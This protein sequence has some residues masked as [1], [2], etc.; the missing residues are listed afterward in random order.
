M[1]KETMQGLA[2]DL[3]AHLEEMLEGI[4]AREGKAY[5]NSLMEVFSMLNVLT[6][7]A[8]IADA[9][10]IPHNL[11]SSLVTRAAAAFPIEVCTLSY[12]RFC[13]ETK[14]VFDTNN[15][16][17]GIASFLTDLKMIQDKQ[18]EFQ[19]ILEKKVNGS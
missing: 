8:K 5:K 13:A 17:S 16:L 12:L 4:E 14:S 7:A 10:G 18:A 19:R 2:Q 3:T 6:A 15:F 11:L 9:A 1:D